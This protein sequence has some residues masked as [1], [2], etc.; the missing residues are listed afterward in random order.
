[1]LAVNLGESL[2][3]VDLASI[4]T[5]AAFFLYGVVRG[6]M[7][8]LA[9]IVVLV[10]AIV[11]A[12]FASGP[13]GGWLTEKF[14]TLTATSAKYI[15]FAIVLIVTLAVGIA[16]AHLLRGLL[17]KAKM[18]AY[19][20]LLGG[21][22]GVLKGALLLIVLMQ[23]YLNLVVPEGEEPAGMAA[24]IVASKAGSAA[25]WSSERLLVFLPKDIS[26]RLREHDRLNEPP[27]D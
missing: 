2:N 18:L 23:L 13:L 4:V 24:D 1:M 8:Q 16:L 9:S 5:L 17:D 11:A 21:V 25:R 22:L 14:P 6:F 26:A 12:S 10:L 7:I 19:D 20:R 3:W 15:C 27:E